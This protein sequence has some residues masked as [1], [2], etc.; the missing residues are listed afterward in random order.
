MFKVNFVAHRETHAGAFVDDQLATEVGLLF[1]TFHKE[2]LGAAVELPVDMTNRLACVVEPVFGKLHGKPMERTLVEACDEAL[3]NLSCQKLQAPKL[4]K[5]IPI[6][7]KVQLQQLL[8]FL[9]EHPL[10]GGADVLV[11]NL[12][13]FEVQYGGDVHDAVVA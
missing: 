7:A 13:T 8:Q 2:L 1:I 10:R 4:G 12:T 6:D 11:N 5:P 3:H 9:H